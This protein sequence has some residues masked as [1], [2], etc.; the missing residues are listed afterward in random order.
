MCMYVVA[1][2]VYYL[3]ALFLFLLL[4]RT[5]TGRHSS[6]HA[7]FWHPETLSAQ[8][9]SLYVLR[10]LLPPVVVVVVRYLG[11]LSLLYFEW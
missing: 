2:V 6:V 10:G 8:S 7:F 11:Y 3:V 9:E 5:P 1:V 4:S